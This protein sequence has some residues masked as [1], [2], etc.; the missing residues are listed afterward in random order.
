VA[1]GKIIRALPLYVNSRKIAEV[2]GGSYEHNSNDEMQ[3]ATEGYMGHSDGADTCRV[4]ANTITP[5]K[6]HEL[7]LKRIIL[8]KEYCTVGIPVDGGYEQFDGRMT[9]RSYNWDTKNGSCTGQF[10]FEGGKPDVL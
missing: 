2:S 4:Q 8:N 9:S 6:G 1:K 3:I 5:V 7:E 10:T